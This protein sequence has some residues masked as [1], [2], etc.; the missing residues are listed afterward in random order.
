MSDELVEVSEEKVMQY[1]DIT[2]KS[3]RKKQHLSI[4]KTVSSQ[5]NWQ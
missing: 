3:K 4:Q 1:L 5:N 2:K